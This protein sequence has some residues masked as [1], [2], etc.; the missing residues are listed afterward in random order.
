MWGDVGRTRA[1]LDVRGY[2]RGSLALPPTPSRSDPGSVDRPS[3][4]G[5]GSRRAARPP[6][7]HRSD[8][9]TDAKSVGSG[10]LGPSEGRA[11][12][13]RRGPTWS[14]AP[15]AVF[16]CGGRLRGV[17]TAGLP[18]GRTWR[19]VRNGAS[20]GTVKRSPTGFRNRVGLKPRVAAAQQP[21]ATEEFPF[22]ERAVGWCSRAGRSIASW[23]MEEFP[24]R[25]RARRSVVCEG[26]LAVG[27]RVG[28]DAQ[29]RKPMPRRGGRPLEYG[30]IRRF[31]MRSEA[32]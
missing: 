1:N 23:A 9:P 25:E 21:W 14:T 8:S 22:R 19:G 12:G 6:T 5:R 29:V 3:P 10:G 18:H 7:S 27:E 32:A 28:F 24:Y 13:G 20:R 30:A 15:S 11:D 31:P 16:P 2:G 17:V 26:K 4:C